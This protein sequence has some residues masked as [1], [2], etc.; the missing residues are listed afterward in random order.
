MKLTK[1]SRGNVQKLYNKEFEISESVVKPVKNIMNTSMAY[2]LDKKMISAN[3]AEDVDLPKQKKKTEF[4]V[5]FNS[6][7]LHGFCGFRTGNI[8]CEIF[9]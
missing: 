6:D 3:P 1:L 8:K 2:A 7:E 4:R 9:V 5:R